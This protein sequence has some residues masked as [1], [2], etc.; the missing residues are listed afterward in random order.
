MFKIHFAKWSM[1]NYVYRLS[2]F[3]QTS[4]CVSITKTKYDT[5]RT[6]EGTDVQ[7]VWVCVC[8]CV[9]VC[10]SALANVSLMRYLYHVFLML[11]TSCSQKVRPYNSSQVTT[12]CGEGKQK[13]RNKLLD[14]KCCLF[15]MGG[16]LGLSH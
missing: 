1:L 15:R 3:S 10:V 16:K 11:Q 2:Y 14:M 4:Q 13:D 8:V 7:S 9:C 5:L 12:W 6:F